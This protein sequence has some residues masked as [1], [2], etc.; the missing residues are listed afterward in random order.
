MYP[1][2]RGISEWSIERK[3]RVGFRAVHKRVCRVTIGGV[4]GSYRAFCCSLERIGRRTI[5]IRELG[6]TLGE[7]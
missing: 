5:L 2:S 4:Q 1:I 6:E 7:S 3:I